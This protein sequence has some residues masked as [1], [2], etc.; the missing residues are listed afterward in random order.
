MWAEKIWLNIETSSFCN[1]CCGHCS[2]HNFI[3]KDKKF[4]SKSLFC[5]II[6]EL[7]ENKIKISNINPFF[8]GEPLFHPD[9]SFFMDYIKTKYMEFP[10]IDFVSIHTNGVYLSEENA[11]SILSLSNQRVL[12]HPNNLFISIDAADSE[13]YKNVKGRDCYYKVIDNIENFLIERQ[14]RD[15]IGPDIVFQFVVTEKNK[16]NVC[17]FALNIYNLTKKFSNKKLK[18]LSSLDNS[19]FRVE[20]DTLYFRLCESNAEFADF[21]RDI[22]KEC[23]LELNKNSIIRD[24]I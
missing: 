10:F 21:Y 15:Q 14:K 19:P 6:D 7:V 5:K 20:S 2:Q 17:D 3:L 22:Y 8:R 13:T 12:P 24:I 16:H 1:L 4:I 23:L 18:F 9:F 11:N